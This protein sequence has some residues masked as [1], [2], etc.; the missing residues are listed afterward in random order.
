MR[1]GRATAAS[2]P[3]SSRSLPMSPGCVTEVLVSDNQHVQPRRRAVPDRSRAL[4]AGAAPGRGGGGRQGRGSASRPDADYERYNAAQRRCGL[5]SSGSSWRRRPRRRPRP[6]TTRRS[7]TATSP[8]STS[9]APR[10]A[11]PSTAS[12]HQ[13]GAAAGRPTSP[14]ASGVMALIDAGHAAR[15]GLFR[16]DQAAA[17]PCRRHGH[18]PAARRGVRAVGPRREHRRRH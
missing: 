17:H 15:R 7:P 5:A 18:R 8:S 9:S 13:H 4:H 12:D 2:A 11:P 10:C 3:T 14:S 1:R 6:P 16:G